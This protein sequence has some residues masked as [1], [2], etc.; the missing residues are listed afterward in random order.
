MTSRYVVKKWH[1]EETYFLREHVFS[2]FSSL[3]CIHP[4]MH[5]FEFII[6]LIDGHGNSK[7]SQLVAR[8]NYL[9]PQNGWKLNSR[10]VYCSWL[11]GK[12]K[13]EIWSESQV[14]NP[15]LKTR[16]RPENEK[17]ENEKLNSRFT[18]IGHLSYQFFLFSVLFLR[19]V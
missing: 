4:F 17:P 7:T 11:Y 14:S 2:L 16:S 6:C 5:P 19:M 13:L 1:K 8:L 9:Y 18:L 3:L 15:D 12:L 10:P